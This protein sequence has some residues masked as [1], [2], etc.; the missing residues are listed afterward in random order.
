MG[1]L[2]KAIHLLNCM[3]NVIIIEQYIILQKMKKVK[4][5]KKKQ[6]KVVTHTEIE[7]F[8]YY[9]VRYIS[10]LLNLNCDKVQI[11][12]K[13]YNKLELKEEMNFDDSISALDYE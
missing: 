2:F 6:E 10:G 5:Q 13:C 12:I 9:S 4:K 1:E 11:K 7:Y 8:D 3:Q